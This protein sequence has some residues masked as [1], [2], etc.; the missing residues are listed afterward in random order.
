[1]AAGP[2]HIVVVG[3][4]VFGAASAL[5]LRARGW[6]VTLLDPHPL[7][8]EG[9]S[10]TDVSK[11]VRMDYGSDVFYHE[12]A[13]AALA[14]WDDWNAAWPRRL[15][16]QDGL[17]V[18]SRGPMLPGG[19]EY[20][21][22]R[23]LRERGYEPERL[24]ERTLAER[25][26][27][28]RAA[29]F[30]DGYV[31]ARA[32]WAESAAVV[33]RLLDLARRAGISIHLDGF[34]SL[35]D[36][37]SR[38]AGVVT[39]SGERIVADRV[40]VCAGA[41][42]PTLLPWLS[43]RLWTVAQPVLHFRA[44]DPTAF[45]GERFP[46]WTADIAGSGWYGFP[47]IADGSV[48][49]GHHGTGARVHPEARGEVSREHVAKARAFLRDALPALADAPL[50]QHRVCLYCDTFDGDFL[51][52]HDPDREGL[53]VASGGSGHAFKFAPV[54]GQIIADAVERRPHRG[55]ER[56]GWRS[57]GGRRAEEARFVGE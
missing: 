29:S 45:R 21:S 11:L 6:T 9:A 15:Y 33:E 2:G 17:L 27:A 35:V 56:F 36:A 16:H 31:N 30:P 53:V 5:E 3:G 7:P 44:A 40:L 55:S 48:K 38:V 18:L 34:A 25:F 8:Y 28:W 54:L 20:E 37:G 19:F 43:D 46:P 22:W 12:L 24:S 10:S 32:G 4:G 26:P 49:I 42:T 41:W 52:D 1:M 47:A 50:V 13:E 14:G 23:G 51:I 39:T 57:T